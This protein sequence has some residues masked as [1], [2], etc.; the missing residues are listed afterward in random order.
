MSTISLVRTK[1][2]FEKNANGDF[3]IFFLITGIKIHGRIE[4]N[5]SA[6]YKKIGKILKMIKKGELRNVLFS[7][8]LR[9]RQV[10]FIKLK[11]I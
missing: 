6:I 8:F 1:Q 11:K 5:Y 10:F 9:E 2:Q 7:S 4:N 3:S